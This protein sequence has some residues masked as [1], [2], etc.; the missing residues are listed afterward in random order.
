MSDKKKSL[1]VFKT[2][3][4]EDIAAIIASAIIVAIVLIYMAFVVPSVNLNAQQDGKLTEVFVAEGATVKKGD[5]LYSLEVVKKKWKDNVMEEKH[6]IQEFTAKANGKVLKIAGKIGDKVKKDKG[7]IIQ[8][9]HQRG[10][11]P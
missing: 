4:H 10:T 8:L 2:D 9:S 6:V 5:K 7:L 3:R 1:T 11:L